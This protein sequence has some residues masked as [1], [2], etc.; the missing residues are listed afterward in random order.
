MA[1]C[2]GFSAYFSGSETA[3]FS[4][5]A[6][7]IADLKRSEGPASHAAVRLLKHPRRL[8]TTILL[9]NMLVNILF[10]S[11]SAYVAAWVIAQHGA[12]IGVGFGV[13]V[14][15]LVIVFGEVLPKSISVM[16]PFRVVLLVALPMR[17]IQLV[18]LPFT[19]ILNKITDVIHLLVDR[20]STPI[21]FVTPLELKTLLEISSEV[22]S[23]DRDAGAMI[24]EV[25]DLSDVKV[26]EIML[27]RVDMDLFDVARPAT[28]LLGLM[29]AE[30]VALVTVY[31]GEPDHVLGI[32]RLKHI[33]FNETRPVRNAIQ[34][35][36]FIPETARVENA[37]RQLIQNQVA[38]AFV[39]DE[40]GELV[41]FIT[42]EDMVEEIVGEIMHEHEEEERLIER[43][44]EAEYTLSGD[45]SIREWEEL[46]RLDLP[47]VSVETIGGLMAEL[48]GHIPRVGEEVRYQNI[49]LE[50]LEISHFRVKNVRLTL[51]GDTAADEESSGP[52]HA[53]SRFQIALTAVAVVVAFL[54][55]DPLRILRGHPFLELVGAVL[56]CIMVSGFFAGAETGFYRMNLLR[57]KC[58]ARRG[59]A[60]A[61]RL[62]ALAHS[63][64]RFVAMTLIGV[65][66]SVY[67]ASLMTTDYAATIVGPE[68]AGWVAT[69]LLSPVML[70]MDEIFPKTL[71]Q[72][73]A[74]R[75]MPEVSFLLKW[76]ARLLRPLILVLRAIQK[77]PELFLGKHSEREDALYSPR[78]IMFFLTDTSAETGMTVYQKTL[79][80]NILRL[81][82]TCVGQTMVPLKDIVKIPAHISMTAFRHTMRDRHY[83]RFPVYEGPRSNIIG[84]IHLLDILRA[85]ETS[86]IPCSDLAKP[87]WRLNEGLSVAHA[88]FE[89]QSNHQA[90]AVVVN[91][92]GR[93]VG[94]VTIK[95][96]VEEI[97]GELKVW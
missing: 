54:V 27:P 88:L 75:L 20:V 83:T 6:D 23:L 63:P 41:G 30:S 60:R 31:E 73:R 81:K 55:L 69:L 68:Q 91:P 90:M 46:F 9:G 21:R 17:I 86:D 58:R 7:R 12:S 48:L 93:A 11:L 66:T 42:L 70:V 53:F 36:P 2:L 35:I 1:A 40:Y 92:S 71:F 37:L 56:G 78:K 50:V 82:R 96:L 45:L 13:A 25:L 72:L 64:Q 77:L 89:L 34:K 26:K 4:L 74:N 28:E 44:G 47:E 57:I 5:T 38:S 49:R 59:D 33:C 16:M 14:L 65:N 52:R 94:I 8:L 43:T 61:R 39:V 3:L 19:V 95:D 29:K 18:L 84:I 85:P 87:A 10:Y 80:R 76:L 67:I 32:V 97:V 51:L 15:L 62:D 79:T 24:A 22:G